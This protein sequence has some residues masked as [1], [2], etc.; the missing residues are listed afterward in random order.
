[1]T[2]R[3]LALALA[4]ALADKMGFDI[5][6]LDLREASAFTDFFVIASGSSDRQVRAL[7]D[8]VLERAA[9]LHAAPLGTEGLETC[10]WVLVDLGGVVVHLFQDKVRDYY[11]LERLWGEADAIA[12]PR[13]AGAA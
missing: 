6:V 8:A 12:L 9:R 4:A 7:A 10:R 5:R 1:L 2:G 13:A 11:A 3:K